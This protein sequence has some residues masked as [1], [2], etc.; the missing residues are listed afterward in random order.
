MFKKRKKE[1]TTEDAP[2]SIAPWEML[3]EEEIA[4]V[5]AG[6]KGRYPALIAFARRT[7]TGAI[8]GW[9]FQERGRDQPG[10]YGTEVLPELFRLVRRGLGRCGAVD[11]GRHR[12]ARVL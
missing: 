8:A 3:H 11:I 1:L 7:D 6:L 10:A 5:T 12:N 9:H 2:D 4:G